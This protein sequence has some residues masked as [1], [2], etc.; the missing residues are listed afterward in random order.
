M[1]PARTLKTLRSTVVALFLSVAGA[2]A[3]GAI[4]HNRLTKSA[5]EKDSVVSS[6]PAMIRLWFAEPPEPA[7]SGITLLRPD[8]TKVTLEKLKKT[9]DPLSVSAALAAPLA[10][11]S[12]TVEWK[13]SGKDGHVIRGKYQFTFKP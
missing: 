9:D 2:T 11:G 8:S 1:A 10:P 4:L 13:A 5:P 7:L 12:Y 6:A 3:A